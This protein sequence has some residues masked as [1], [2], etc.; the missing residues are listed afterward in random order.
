MYYYNPGL[1]T[2]TG[3]LKKGSSLRY[4]QFSFSHCFI[5]GTAF[6]CTIP[7][8]TKCTKI[9]LGF[10]LLAFTSHKRFFLLLIWSFK[11]NLALSKTGSNPALERCT[12][13]AW[14]DYGLRV[15]FF[16]KFIN[17]FFNF[18]ILIKIFLASS[19]FQPEGQR[20]SI[21]LIP[22]GLSYFR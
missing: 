15:F 17:I 6:L 3:F 7:H 14:Q 11:R 18:S 21:Y 8:R 20:S 1:Y 5:L 16:Y 12:G 19:N 2:Q 9:F 13:Q 22:L 10:A 4:L